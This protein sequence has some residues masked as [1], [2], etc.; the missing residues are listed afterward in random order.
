MT[1]PNILTFFRISLVPLILATLFLEQNLI[2]LSLLFLA[3]LSDLLDGILARKLNQE[4]DLGRLL[5]PV[6]DKFLIT[7]LFATLAYLKDIPVWVCALVLGRDLFIGIGV[8]YLRRLNLKILY[9]PMWISKVN[10]FLQLL[11]VFLI[12]LQKVYF[13]D[14]F[15]MVLNVILIVMISTTV[16]S[17]WRYV[18]LFRKLIREGA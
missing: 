15:K 12:L 18:G 13:I 1:F 8:L 3:G 7:T 9:P 16:F 17:F 11:L 14:F 10:T 4:T 5:D 2:A 6:A